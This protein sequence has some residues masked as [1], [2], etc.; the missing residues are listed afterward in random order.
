MLRKKHLFATP[1]ATENAFYDAI[2]RADLDA[3]MALW[4]DDEDIVCVHPGATRLIGH[5]AIRA[6][7][8]AIFARGGISIRPVGRQS[9]QS[10]MTATH[11][12]IEEV[13]N[14][15]LSS[16]DLTNSESG[17]DIY[18]P[19]Q[20]VLATNVFLKTPLG[21]RITLHHTSIAPGPAP[22]EPATSTTLH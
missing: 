20:H 4:A 19:Q 16:S 22:G 7:W 21:W 6:S 3:L 18:T 8:Q 12:I 10:A 1:D 9:M 5:A 17:L 14:I 2:G 11:H 13:G 15:S